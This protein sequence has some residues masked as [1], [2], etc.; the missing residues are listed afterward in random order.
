MAARRTK[1]MDIEMDGFHLA[2]MKIHDRAER[3]PY[4]VLWLYGNGG[5]RYQKQLAKYGD[6]ISCICFIKDLFLDGA[7][8]LTLAGLIDWSNEYHG[9]IA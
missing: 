8:V 9:R 5:W 2:V 7:N 6:I 1:V 4:R 3:N